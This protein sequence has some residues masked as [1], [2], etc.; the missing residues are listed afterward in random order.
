[1]F[2]KA[3]AAA[4]RL[5]FL[6]R[7]LDPRQRFL[8]IELLPDAVHATSLRVWPRDRRVEIGKSWFVRPVSE[9]PQAIMDALRTALR[10]ARFL[11]RPLAVVAFSP[12]LGATVHTSATLVR[13]VPYAPI[14]DGEFCAHINRGVR[15]LIDKHRGRAAL[16]TGVSEPEILLTDL[17]LKGVRLDAHHVVN[18]VDFTAKT[19]ELRFAAT[20]AARPFVHALRSL[21]GARRIALCGE[22]GAFSAHALAQGYGADRSF[23]FL[24]LLH[25]RTHVFIC[26]GGTV[27]Y[28]D[29]LPWGLEQLLTRIEDAFAVG[30]AVARLMYQRYLARS[31]SAH[32][33]REFERLMTGECEVFFAMLS[34]VISE[35]EVSQA[36]LS[37]RFALPDFLSTASFR[38]KV[39]GRVR[40]GVCTP[41]L[42]A[43]RLGIAVTGES[44]VHPA[45][46]FSAV[47]A[48]AACCFSPRNATLNTVL[49]QQ[50]RWLLQ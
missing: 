8:F 32:F 26:D 16:K 36:Y 30:P 46:L 1:M 48:V 3:G 50:A 21:L 40:I 18:P 27:A 33:L 23:L 31:V 35:Y 14:S 28:V 43:Q 6:R 34:P 41:D 11:R 15:K 39:P 37:P 49:R 24:E 47:A 22:G 29:M 42:L 12:P 5:G 45:H 19:I 38:N 25:D 20:F 9:R 2:T 10:R 44:R 13:D 7:L 17:T 4:A